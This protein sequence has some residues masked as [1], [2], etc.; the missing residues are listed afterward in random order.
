MLKTT[1]LLKL[2]NEG[3]PN[4]IRAVDDT[5][6]ELPDTGLVMLFGKSGCG[7]TTL[8]NCIGGLDKTQKGSVTIDGITLTGYNADDWD[9]VRNEKIGYIFQNYNLLSEYSVYRNIEFAL[10]IAGMTDKKEMKKRIIYALQLVGMD[11]Y[12]NRL[13]KSLSGG[14][15]Q[16][17]GIA[18]AI[19]KSPSIII[20]DEPTGNLDD[21]NTLQILDMLKQISAHCLV[22][23]VTHE[24]RIAR[25]Y[26]DRVIQIVD[27]KVVNDVNASG[28]ERKLQHATSDKI[29]LGDMQLDETS[30]AN[31]LYKLYSDKPLEHVEV[32][33]AYH[34]GQLYVR[35]TAPVRVQYVDDKSEI[36]LLDE[37]YSDKQ[38]GEILNQDMNLDK[39]IL[40]PIKYQKH[41]IFHTRKIIKDTL[42]RSQGL[43]KKKR[44][45]YWLMF[46]LSIIMTIILSVF[47]ENFVYN[48]IVDKQ[49]DD[50]VIGIVVPAEFLAEDAQALVGSNGI[51]YALHASSFI[52]MT[53]YPKY[54]DTN[55]ASAG[56][57]TYNDVSFADEM[58]TPL[59]LSVLTNETY[60]VGGR[61]TNVESIVIDAMLLK[62]FD[63]VEGILKGQ[64]ITDYRQMLGETLELNGNNYTIAGIVNGG[65]PSIYFA[66]SVYNS[67]YGALT[68]DE[69]IE[70]YVFDLYCTDKAAAIA[71]LE[72]Q[73]YEVRNY[74]ETSKRD[75][76]DVAFS[77]S[78]GLLGIFCILF[79][80]FL[81][82]GKK[83]A[84]G[85]YILRIHD[86][87]IMRAIG[88]TKGNIMKQFMV[89]ALTISSLTCLSG[90]LLTSIGLWAYLSK[91]V[92]ARTIFYY[93]VWIALLVI[94]GLT[95]I[96]VISYVG[97]AYK[98]LK[99]TPAEILTKY[100]V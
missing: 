4:E 48:E 27:G 19:A 84:H 98:V 16:R 57:I 11:K 89:E 15:Q 82:S 34:D 94:L 21:K 25:F 24:E 59:P 63:E 65:S 9:A 49:L 33:M 43:D 90:T 91:N 42:T 73:N 79:L 58:G 99:K 14:Q 85:G 74:E 41:S 95:A 1:N 26:A 67:L 29:F 97:S 100:D 78:S 46:I 55:S 40:A 60:E 6:F 50:H 13:P 76:Y 77:Q 28:V 62:R 70:E 38:A 39:E 45:P 88:A 61:A 20:A 22:V 81:I 93:P 8:L 44:T 30:S 36:L 32:T 69:S 56:V 86:I 2:Y 12:K 68:Y 66:D 5:T 23:L 64:G 47:A 18:R 51:A 87:G 52:N 7:K 31:A 3:K 83:L 37:K 96:N 71:Y 53:L 92:N 80:I 35:A 17:V 10:E 75:F 54:Y 72:S